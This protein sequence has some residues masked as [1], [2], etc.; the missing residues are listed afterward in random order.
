M[1][2]TGILKG[3]RNWFCQRPSLVRRA[4]RQTRLKQERHDT[5]RVSEG[6]LKKFAKVLNENF[7]WAD[8]QLFFLL[9]SLSG[10]QWEKNQR[11][12]RRRRLRRRRRWRRRR[13]LRFKDRIGTQNLLLG[14]EPWSS[15]YLTRLMFRRFESQRGILDKHFFTIICCEN[16]LLNRRHRRYNGLTNKPALTSFFI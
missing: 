13:W 9:E 8:F 5:D 3:V 16:L 15:G 14:R 11:R 1:V 6:G 12:R 10:Q 7:S 4:E 2:K